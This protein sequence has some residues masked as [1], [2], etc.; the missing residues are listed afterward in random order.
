[1]P[2]AMPNEIPRAFSCVIYKILVGS[3]SVFGKLG[4]QYIKFKY[5]KLF[6]IVLN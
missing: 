4:N 5:Q 6:Y 2:K 1:M 3:F